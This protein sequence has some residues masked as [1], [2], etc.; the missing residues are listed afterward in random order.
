MNTCGSFPSTAE[1]EIC[2]GCCQTPPESQFAGANFRLDK[3]LPSDRTGSWCLLH[4]A[5]VPTK[6]QRQFLNITLQLFPLLS[7][8]SEALGCQL[9]RCQP[10]SR[11]FHCNSWLGNVAQRTPKRRKGKGCFTRVR[12]GAKIAR[13]TVQLAKAPWITSPRCRGDSRTL[14]LNPTHWSSLARELAQARNNYVFNV[15]KRKGFSDRTKQVL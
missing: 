14:V 1:W 4:L 2:T 6:K 9:L 13:G 15:W 12:I 5:W 7:S 3:C 10:A 8:C 11:T